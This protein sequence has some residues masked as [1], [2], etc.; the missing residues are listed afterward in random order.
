M[1]PHVSRTPTALFVTLVVVGG[2]L[3]G[4]QAVDDPAPVSSAPPKTSRTDDSTPERADH[5]SAGRR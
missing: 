5:P 1:R 4:C 3:T 2:T